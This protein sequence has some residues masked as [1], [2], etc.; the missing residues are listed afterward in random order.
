MRRVDL[1]DHVAK[2]PRSLSGG[3]AQRVALARALVI[4]PRLLLLDEPFRRARREHPRPGSRAAATPPGGLPGHHRHGHP[5]PDGCDGSR[6]PAS[7]DRSRTCR[8]GGHPHRD[9]DAPAQRLRGSPRRP[10]P[11]FWRRPGHHGRPADGGTL[12]TTPG[13]GDVLL[14]LPPSAVS[15]HRTRPD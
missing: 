6:R 5:R 11:L 1:A 14:A 2:R 13:T 9:R 12:T 15:L 10:Q 4:D 8:A 3:Q 7:G